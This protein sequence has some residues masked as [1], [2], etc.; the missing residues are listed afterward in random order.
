MDKN[1]LIRVRVLN[2][3]I[4]LLLIFSFSDGFIQGFSEGWHS[5]ET[6]EKKN[7]SI[8]LFFVSLHPTTD[9][10]EIQ[11][12][13]NNGSE[14]FVTI[15]EASVALHNSPM[16]ISKI[17]TDAVV[18]L[19]AL[20]IIIWMIVLIWRITNSFSRGSLL[21]V[22]NILR[23]RSIGILLIAKELLYIAMQYIDLHYLKSVMQV[24]GYEMVA[25]ISYTQII[26][27][28]IMLVFAEILVVANRMREEQELTI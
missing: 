8:E 9:L 5:A 26:V 25:D 10:K 17:V 6:S 15:S 14:A 7:V 28:L 22:E 27:G 19:L 4:A 2:V 20:V 12:T 18:V 16:P 21:T 13:T 11:A 3:I 1:L 24:K 23:F